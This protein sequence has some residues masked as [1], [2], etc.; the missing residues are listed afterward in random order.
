MSGER[1]IELNRVSCGLARG[2]VGT[3]AKRSEAERS[4]AKQSEAERS[5]AKQSEAERS[6]AGTFL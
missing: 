2:E 3:G 4:G 6:D 1:G 5:R